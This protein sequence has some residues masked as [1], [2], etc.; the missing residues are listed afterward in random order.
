MAARASGRP[1]PPQNSGVPPM[2]AK[3]PSGRS[4]GRKLVARKLWA[5]VGRQRGVLSAKRSPERSLGRKTASRIW[6]TR[7]AFGG[8]T[9]TGTEFG[10]EMVARTEFWPQLGHQS[11]VLE[12]PRPKTTANHGRAPCPGRLR[13]FDQTRLRGTMVPCH[14][15][16]MT[17]NVLSESHMLCK[18]IQ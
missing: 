13:G 6:D 11:K 5:Q 9:A 16:D 10:P 7:S 18:N 8:K 4:F 3:R 17:R 15:K 2:V 1:K 12:H 14:N